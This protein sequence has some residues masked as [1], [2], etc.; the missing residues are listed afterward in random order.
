[1]PGQVSQQSPT[2]SFIVSIGFSAYTAIATVLQIGNALHQTTTFPD[3]LHW[4]AANWW[5]VTQSLIINPA[6]YYRFQQAVRRIKEDDAAT[7]P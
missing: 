4:I 3:T 1:M 2:R 5:T 7:G 6:P